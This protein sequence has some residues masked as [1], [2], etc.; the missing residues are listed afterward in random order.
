M[1]IEQ[2]KRSASKAD[3]IRRYEGLAGDSRANS[4][5]HHACRESPETRVVCELQSSPMIGH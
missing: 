3:C 4:L 5:P 1:N 2:D